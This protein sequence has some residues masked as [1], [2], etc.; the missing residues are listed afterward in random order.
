MVGEK[1]NVI[2]K[3]REYDQLIKAIVL[4]LDSN[5]SDHT[6]YE[7]KKEALGRI[8]HFPNRWAIKLLKGKRS[9]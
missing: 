4:E 5:Y 7:W 3:S 9:M 8:T 6:V 1:I 2:Y